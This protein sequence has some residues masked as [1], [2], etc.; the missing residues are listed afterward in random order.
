MNNN[1]KKPPTI[2][3]PDDGANLPDMNRINNPRDF[4]FLQRNGTWE[5]ITDIHGRKFINSKKGKRGV[6]V[7]IAK[8]N[9]ATGVNPMEPAMLMMAAPEMANLLDTVQHWG[10]VILKNLKPLEHEIMADVLRDICNLLDKIQP[11]S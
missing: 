6:P 2:T 4:R 11:Q 8:I 7:S 5:M 10:P 3:I 9:F 1:E